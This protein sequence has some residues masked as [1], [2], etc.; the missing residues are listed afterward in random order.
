MW[1][2]VSARLLKWLGLDPPQFPHLL[3][4][5]AEILGIQCCLQQVGWQPP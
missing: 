4:E 1:D 5:E 3:A 2:S